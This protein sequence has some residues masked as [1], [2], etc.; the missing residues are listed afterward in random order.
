MY[1][2]LEIEDDKIV[3]HLLNKTDLPTKYKDQYNEEVVLRD[4]GSLEAFLNFV[5]DEISYSATDIYEIDA[6]GA[7]NELF[8]F[9]TREYQGIF[10]VDALDVDMP[11][12][13]LSAKAAKDYAADTASFFG[14]PEEI[15]RDEILVRIESLE[16]VSPKGLK[17]HEFFEFLKSKLPDDVEI[18]NPLIL[19]ASGCSSFQKNERLKYQLEIAKNNGL[20][21]EAL[22]FLSELSESDW[23]EP[24]QD[25][26]QEFHP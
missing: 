17:W 19:A 3:D 15:L 10:F 26:Y 23:E 18:D 2:I 22:D 21:D 12:Y 5:E 25:I 20:L 24:N 9:R 13:F 11:G 14:K 6:V 7:D 8:S 1:D 4:E 16:L